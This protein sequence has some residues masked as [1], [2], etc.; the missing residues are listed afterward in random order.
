MK[1]SVDRVKDNRV[2]IFSLLGIGFV[3]LISNILGKNIAKTTTDFLFVPVSGT[4]LILAIIIAIRFK[5][6]GSFGLSYIFFAGFAATWFIAELIW[7]NYELLG[8]SN[9]FPYID[10]A[11]YLSGYVFLWLFS[12]YYLKPVG[13]A[14]SK[15]MLGYAFL[16][17]TVFLV[18]TFYTIYSSNPQ[19]S[20][21]EI[22]WA[23]IYP[24]LDA[25]LLFPTVIAM[26]LFF[27]GSVSFLWSLMFIAIL[28]NIVADSGFL[29]LDLDKSYSS[30]SPID[31][32][33][34]WAYVLFSVGLY[35]QIKVFKKQKMK[36]FG[37]LDEFK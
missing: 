8:K 24:I 12:R 27:K 25:V 29:Y 28:L 35:S 21:Q 5:G 23:G 36:S 30:G 26:I 13:S 10:D 9:P 34:L 7:M 16:A 17:M 37:K 19:A 4:L 31:I 6:K 22:V 33:Y 20:L 14:I 32:L 1:P 15:K 3:V 11:V 2:L 18:P